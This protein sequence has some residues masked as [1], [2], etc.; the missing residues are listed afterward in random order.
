MDFPLGGASPS[1]AAPWVFRHIYLSPCILHP[2]SLF[3]SNGSKTMCCCLKLQENCSKSDKPRVC[4]C[5]WPRR[6]RQS[7]QCT[8]LLSL[9]YINRNKP[10]WVYFGGNLEFL[11]PRLLGDPQSNY[12]PCCCCGYGVVQM[13]SVAPGEAAELPREAKRNPD[14]FFFLSQILPVI[15]FM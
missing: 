10:A 15:F 3:L 13:A 8:W 12:L 7:G 4:S 6:S 1:P 14:A 5:P 9:R 11:R 2:P